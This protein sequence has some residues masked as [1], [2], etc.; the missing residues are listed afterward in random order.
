MAEKEWIQARGEGKGRTW[1]LSAALYRALE[2]SAGYV[3]M[4]G[5]EPLQQEQ[6]VLAFVSAHGRINRAQAA[7]LCAI[8]PEQAGRLLR[9]LAAEGKLIQRGERRGSF[10]EL[11]DSRPD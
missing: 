3:R 8:A 4:R 7:E 11:P 5:F 6:M 10:Y 1:H 9:R 2:S